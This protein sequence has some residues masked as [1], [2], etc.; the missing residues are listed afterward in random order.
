[1]FFKYI[2]KSLLVL[3]TISALVGCNSTIK[4]GKEHYNKGITCLEGG[5]YEEAEA[6]LKS[7]IGNDPDKAEYYI[8]YGMALSKNGKTKKA[9]EQFDKG[10]K[11]KNNQIVRQNNKLAYRGKGIACYESQEYEKAE[12]Y[13]KK[14]LEI[15]DYKE[16]DN[17]IRYYLASIFFD[18]EKYDE[19]MKHYDMILKQDSKSVDAYIGKAKIYNK[20]GEVSK[21]IENYDYAL[22]YRENAYEVYIEKYLM[23]QEKNKEEEAK[24]VLLEADKKIVEK[25]EE[26][27]FY[28]AIISYY[29]GNE[30]GAIDKLSTI[31]AK[32]YVNAY[33]YLGEIYEGKKDYSNAAYDYAKFIEQCKKCSGE[34]YNKLAVCYVKTQQYEKAAEILEQGIKN[35]RETDI[36]KMKKN[37]IAVYEKM[38]DY[39]KAYHFAKE[40]IEEYPED[41]QVKKEYK[42]L[43]TRVYENI[44][45]KD[46]KVK[47]GKDNKEISE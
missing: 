15:K 2:G 11:D 1:M 5:S 47:S 28:K 4:N 25:T 16:Q 38:S 13:F 3:L 8:A 42:F 30:S 21:A 10:I 39:E 44:S 20:K 41:K 27:S 31:A 12:E 32:G 43:A 23:L 9:L 40:Y 34:V 22:K 7:A 24:K 17:D 18:L 26:D 6:Y 35:V 29:N 45:N 37:L 36:K 33:H 46:E 19:A 14:A